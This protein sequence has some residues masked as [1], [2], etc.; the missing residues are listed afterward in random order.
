VLDRWGRLAGLIT[1]ENIGELM[2]LRGLKRSDELAV[3][4]ARRAMPPPLP[5]V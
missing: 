5:R 4:R 1:P 3:W 2:M